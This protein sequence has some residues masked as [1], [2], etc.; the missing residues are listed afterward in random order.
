MIGRYHP[1]PALRDELTEQDLW[2]A[3]VSADTVG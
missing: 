2:S 1:D 3:P